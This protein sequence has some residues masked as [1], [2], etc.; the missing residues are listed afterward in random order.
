MVNAGYSFGDMLTVKIGIQTVNLPFGN[1]FSDVDSGSPGLV[2]RD[3]EDTAKL[4]VNMGNFAAEYLQGVWNEENGEWEFPEKTALPFT[5]EISLKE[6]YGYL[7]E[8]LL[9]SLS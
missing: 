2:C 8:Y 7:F 4:F 6:K 9:H 3:Q 5:A 1:S